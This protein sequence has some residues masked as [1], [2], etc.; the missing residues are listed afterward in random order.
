MTNLIAE[1]N[2]KQIEKCFDHVTIGVDCWKNYQIM[3]ISCS[4]AVGN[5]S[6]AVGNVGKW[7]E[8]CLK[9]VGQL[10]HFSTEIS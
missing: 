8:S 4:E 9:A 6:E 2:P 7:S 3:S 1:H 5:W 10:Y